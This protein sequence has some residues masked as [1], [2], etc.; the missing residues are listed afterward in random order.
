MFKSKHSESRKY[1]FPIKS[2][3][4]KHADQHCMFALTVNILLKKTTKQKNVEIFWN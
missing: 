3:M 4:N 2:L 1:Y